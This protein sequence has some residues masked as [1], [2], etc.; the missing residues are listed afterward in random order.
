VRPTDAD[1]ARALRAKIASPGEWGT[2]ANVQTHARY[3]QRITGRG[4]RAICGCG[5]GSRCTH[6]GMVNGLGMTSGCEWSMRQW[7]RDPQGEEQ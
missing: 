7:V 5:C 2:Y 3:M 4:G 1:T 6:V